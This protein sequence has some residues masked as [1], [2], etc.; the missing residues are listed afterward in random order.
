[1]TR[2]GW[3]VAALSLCA[4]AAT[5]CTSIDNADSGL[6]FDRRGRGI[7]RSY[8]PRLS[9]HTEFR[10]CREPRSSLVINGMVCNVDVPLPSTNAL[11]S[12]AV[13][14]KDLAVA[15][16]PRALRTLALSDLLWGNESGKTL[17]RS[18]SYLSMVSRSDGPHRVATLSDLSAALLV[19][20]ERSQD[21]R[22]VLEAIEAADGATRLDPT[23]V[24]AQYNLALALETAGIDYQA[25]SEWDRYLQLDRDSPWAVEARQHRDRLKS[26]GIRPSATPTDTT[27]SSLIAF[28]KSSPQ[29]ARLY[30][31]NKLLGRW[32]Q[33]E[34]DNNPDDANRVLRQVGVIAQ[35]LIS[36]NGDATLYAA[37]QSI[38][39]IERHPTKLR[40]LA[41][42]HVAF[43]N[44]QQLY[45]SANYPAASKLFSEARAQSVDSRPLSNWASLF[46]GAT[47]IY[48]G[49]AQEGVEIIAR[50]RAIASPESRALV[51]RAT[52]MLGTTHLRLGQYEKAR[53]E[54][55]EASDLFSHCGEREYAGVTHA[56]AADAQFNLG[57]ATAAYVTAVEA[58]RLLRPYHGSVWIH[59]LLAVVAAATAVDGLPATA[60]RIQ[61][62]GLSAAKKFGQP[63]Y[64]AEAHLA[65]ARV[66]VR[67]E[68]GSSGTADI[69]TAEAIIRGMEAGLAQTWLAADL[70]L[71]R[72]QAQPLGSRAKY[73]K[74]LDSAV[75]T[76]RQLQ[77]NLRLLPA[78]LARADASLDAHDFPAARNDL[79]E[80]IALLEQEHDSIGSAALRLSIL[81]AARSVFT[82]AVALAAAAGDTIGALKLLEQSHASLAP[83]SNRLNSRRVMPL[84]APD[85]V[86]GVEYLAISDTL[87]AWAITSSG[88]HMVREPLHGFALADSVAEL[89]TLLEQ[90]AGKLVVEKL[91][92]ALHQRLIAPIGAHIPANNRLVIVAGNDWVAATPFAAL[93]DSSTNRHLVEDHV[94]SFA[95]RLNGVSSGNLS[96]SASRVLLVGNPSF[97]QRRHRT[98]EPLPGSMSEVDSINALYPNAVVLSRSLATPVSVMGS[99]S[100]I[101][102]FHYAGHAVVDRI[103]PLQSYLALSPG[104][105]ADST[106]ALT[107][108]AIQHSTF[109]SLRLVVLSACE[110]ARPSLANNFGMNGLTLAFLAGGAKAVIGSL[111]RV[112]DQSTRSLM[113]RFYKDF[114]N[115]GDAAS[116]LQRAQIEM[117]QAPSIAARSPAAWSAFQHVIP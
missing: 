2:E 98:L 90:H 54:F 7:P 46:Y 12:V 15:L 80:S 49:K 13:A 37:L 88:I 43:A 61:S 38:Q 9:I 114:R 25:V 116:A 34:L 111:W 18:I 29:D 113:V 56:L 14:Q 41:H 3:T 20:A 66:G 107:A 92:V 95:N 72:S 62:E 97:D 19:R 81:S 48:A 22:D 44:G 60:F 84:R 86:T 33:F 115:T 99:F 11:A 78:L 5:G 24:Q 59:N 55:L 94:M 63:V 26:E 42:A 100:G 106:G 112:D 45:Q 82:R 65:R 70:S 10:P 71:T 87:M 47:L 73:Q 64:I 4:F 91:L 96:Y 28:A 69:D 50:V 53:D 110:T 36:S 101:E 67:N 58:L 30:V 76:F 21:V 74:S 104:T 52:W 31:W 39:G 27:S 108:D 77:S 17:D 85:G 68:S 75:A 103:R 79:S 51:A 35:V 57:D 102:V 6:G 32:G 109:S 117:M 1:M 23:Y 89:T 8:S 93:K 16:T 83:I 105:Q 40:S